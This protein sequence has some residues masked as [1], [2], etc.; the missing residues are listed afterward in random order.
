MYG[1]EYITFGSNGN[2]N[3]MFFNDANVAPNTSIATEDNTNIDDGSQT[4]PFNYK[5]PAYLMVEGV[6]IN[7]SYN[8]YGTVYVKGNI[9]TVSASG[10]TPADGSGNVTFSGRA[11]L[12]VNGKTF[13]TQDFSLPSSS[14]YETGTYPMG[15][16]TFNL[17]SNANLQVRIN[18]GYVFQGDEGKIMPMPTQIDKTISIPLLYSIKT[19]GSGR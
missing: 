19:G 18:A 8:V 16:A 13:S 6:G 5:Q 14:I 15:V 9:A 3:V 11:Q 12:L 10:K 2:V 4:I 17:P 1:S 7:G